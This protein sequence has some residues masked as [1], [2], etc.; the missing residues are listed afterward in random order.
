M[1]TRQGYG[2]LKYRYKTEPR[3]LVSRTG[4]IRMIQYITDVCF[5]LERARFRMSTK[6][7]QQQCWLRA[8]IKGRGNR[9]RLA[10]ITPV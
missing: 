10:L 2:M 7:E 9:R 6:F 4:G 5:H 8:Y 1:M 3:A